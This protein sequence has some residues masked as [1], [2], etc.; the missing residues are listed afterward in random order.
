MQV[1][2]LL[3]KERRGVEEIK[4]DI[5]KLIREADAQGVALDAIRSTF[6]FMMDGKFYLTRLDIEERRTA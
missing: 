1:S 4:G 2:N 3:S 5:V 6:V